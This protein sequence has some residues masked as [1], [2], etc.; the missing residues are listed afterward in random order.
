MI[1]QI[2]ASITL[3]SFTTHDADLHYALLRMDLLLVLTKGL[4]VGGWDSCR[5]VFGCLCFTHDS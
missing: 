1:A 2:K 4:G 5:F 3:S